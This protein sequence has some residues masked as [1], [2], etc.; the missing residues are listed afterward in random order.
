M[1]CMNEHRKFQ[2]ACPFV[3]QQ[4]GGSNIMHI[5]DP[6][7]DEMG[8]RGLDIGPDEE[9]NVNVITDTPVHQNMAIESVRLNTFTN[10][11]PNLRQRPT[12]LAKAGFFYC[13]EHDN[14]RCFFCDGGLR[15]W[16]PNDDPWIEHVRWFP[17]CGFVRQSKGPEF[18][19]HVIDQFGQG[20]QLLFQKVESLMNSSMVMYVEN[21]GYHRDI[22]RRVL[23]KQIRMKGENFPNVQNF[24]EALLADSFS[25]ENQPPSQTATSQAMPRG[26][27]QPTV[28]GNQPRSVEVHSGGALG[29][30]EEQKLKQEL[31]ELRDRKKCKVCWDKDVSV[32]FLPCAHL[33]VCTE[34]APALRNC[35]V[36]R[37]AIRGTVRTYMP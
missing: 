33:V 30:S 9:M 2:P 26:A 22:I 17:Q 15:N 35:P 28:Q 32:L 29:L 31:E 24:L 21:M 36:C 3:Q 10:W 6:L 1:L 20:D 5:I 16:E 13:G 25:A 37:A 4:S 14:C 18:I 23:E 11:P 19:R 34:C 27:G 12:E 8:G 7:D